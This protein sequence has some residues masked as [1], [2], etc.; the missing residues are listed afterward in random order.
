MQVYIPC[1]ENLMYNTEARPHG[2][3]IPGLVFA[4]STKISKDS[5]PDSNALVTAGADYACKCTPIVHQNFTSIL[6]CYTVNC[7]LILTDKGQIVILLSLL[8]LVIALLVKHFVLT[9]NKQ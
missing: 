7:T 8:I 3:I 6:E 1:G 5:K 9:E 4:P 2:F